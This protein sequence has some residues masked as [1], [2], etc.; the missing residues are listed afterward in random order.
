[1]KLSPFTKN[2]E[3]MR[4]KILHEAMCKV[5]SERTKNIQKLRTG[6]QNFNGLARAILNDTMSGTANISGSSP[7]SLPP[8]GCGE[9]SDD[10]NRENDENGTPSSGHGYIKVADMMMLDEMAA[11]SFDLQSSM[12]TDEAALIRFLGTEDHQLL[13]DQISE[14][15]QSEYGDVETIDIYLAEDIGYDWAR[16]EEEATTDR[17]II[18]PVCRSSSM[19]IDDATGRCC[20]GALLNLRSAITGQT[21]SADQLRDILAAVYDRHLLVCDA[22]AL[23]EDSCAI[24]SSGKTAG[25]YD[26]EMGVGGIHQHDTEEGM[27]RSTQTIPPLQSSS[28]GGLEFI[29]RDHSNLIALC[30]LCGFAE[31][32]I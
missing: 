15:M 16:E 29:Q 11:A 6:E 31:R 23:D 24:L 7:D 5:K 30:S 20:C 27:L 12:D 22:L 2:K 10:V 28:P 9:D 3:A 17:Y 4:E 14:A 1:M 25:L 32:V 21:L 19:E 18:C 26:D 13:M 8:P